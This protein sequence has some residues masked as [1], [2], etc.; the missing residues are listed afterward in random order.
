MGSK[1]QF[2]PSKPLTQSSL[3]RLVS[4]FYHREGEEC[5]AAI[6]AD[7][8]LKSKLGKEDAEVQR[9]CLDNFTN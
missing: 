7:E 5:P 3:A 6:A 4:L 8:I 1:Q 2:K 9:W